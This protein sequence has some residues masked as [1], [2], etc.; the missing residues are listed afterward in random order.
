MIRA[1]D[2]FDLAVDWSVSDNIKITGGVNNVADDD[3]PIIDSNTLGISAPPFGN[4]NTYPVIYD[5]L[6]REVFVG[7]TTRF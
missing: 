2:Y 4:A 6:G 5:S 3:P 7:M 1:Y